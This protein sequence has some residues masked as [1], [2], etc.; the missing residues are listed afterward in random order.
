MCNLGGGSEI[1]KRIHIWC[2]ATWEAHK[3]FHL[4][5][6]DRP[7]HRG[8]VVIK[9]HCRSHGLLGLAWMRITHP[10]AAAGPSREACCKGSQ[11]L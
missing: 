2:K 10:P 7:Q 3:L 8:W 6:I 9:S 1:L 11:G 5:G 4:S